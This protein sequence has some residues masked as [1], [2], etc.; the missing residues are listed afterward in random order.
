ME[1]A[2]ALLHLRFI[3]RTAKPIDVTDTT[4]ATELLLLDRCVE[5]LRETVPSAKNLQAK[6]AAQLPDG[7]EAQRACDNVLTLVRHY[8]TDAGMSVSPT[9]ASAGSVRQLRFRPA[10]G[11]VANPLA[12]PLP[13]SDP[14]WHVCRRCDRASEPTGF[15]RRKRS[16]RLVCVSNRIS[17]PRRGAAPGG[18][19][20]GMLSALR[21]TGGMWFG[22]SGETT[23]T[24]AD[25]PEVLDARQHPLR[26]D[27]PDAPASSTPT[28][29]ATATA[30]SGRCFTT[31]PS[32][33]RHEQR[34]YDAYQSVNAQFARQLSKLLKPGDAV[35]VH[36][37]HLIPLAR[38][39][40]AA[41]LHGP[42]GFFLH[43]P[44]PHMQVLRLLPNHAELM[45]D[46]CQ[47]DLVGFQTE[48]DVRSFRS[49]ARARGSPEHRARRVR[50]GAYPIG[51]D[52]EADRRGSRPKRWREDTM[53]RMT[54]S[55]LGRKLIIGVD[56]LDY[57]KG[58]TERFAA[59]EHFLET[60]SGQPG[61]GDVPA[62]RAAQ[63]RGRARVLARSAQALE[64]SAGG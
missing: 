44:F 52:V 9:D 59:F 60:L 33:F 1:E 16:K 38:Y 39:L 27:R 22:W 28:T 50:V 24:P 23:E 2:G 17:L 41:R 25:E 46:L 5:S 62:D 53:Q 54:A 37:Y 26:D 42:I 20:V 64:Q 56:R 8:L 3:V 57:S 19:A 31:S 29:T 30:R 14:C 47:Y 6:I 61:Q 13:R 10:M 58:L 40:R 35:W 63:P 55:L 51:V 18:L 34:H 36:D 7:S 45:R 4:L 12:E 49:C 43:I 21:H 11:W 15:R 32:C 48:D